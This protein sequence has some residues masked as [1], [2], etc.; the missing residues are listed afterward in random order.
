MKKKG[1]SKPLP[2]FNSLLLPC[3]KDDQIINDDW[4]GFGFG[5]DIKYDDTLLSDVD[6]MSNKELRDIEIEAILSF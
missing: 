5:E 4:I 6:W 1:K 2:S 3:R